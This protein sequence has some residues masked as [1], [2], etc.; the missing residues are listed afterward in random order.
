MLQGVRKLNIFATSPCPV[1]SAQILDD[2]RK[3]KMILES[4]QILYTNMYE[5]SPSSFNK[6]AYSPLREIKDEDDNFLGYK[7]NV[8]VKYAYYFAGERV[9]APTH[10]NHPSTIWARETR[11]NYIWLLEHFEA[12]CEE[13]KRIYGK[14]HKCFEH[15]GNLDYG[16]HFTM[17]GPLTE[18]PKCM[19]DEFKNNDPHLSY[20]LYMIDKWKN[21]KRSPTWDREYK[22]NKE[23][24][25]M[26]DELDEVAYA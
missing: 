15:Y 12:L 20:Q 24:F 5:L 16:I 19:P 22:N 9:Y 3:V 14:T 17:E 13:Y 8:K 21:D 2:K 23:I 25:I 7:T 6:C 26:L 18:I 1:K 11:A 4:A 10:V